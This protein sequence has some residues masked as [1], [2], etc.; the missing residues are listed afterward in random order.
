MAT[1]PLNIWLL[2]CCA[3]NIY[4]AIT[5]LRWA[6]RHYEARNRFIEA[7]EE[8]LKRMWGQDGPPAK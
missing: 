5:N 7:R 2:V 1:T 3:V 6:R 4:A 8:L